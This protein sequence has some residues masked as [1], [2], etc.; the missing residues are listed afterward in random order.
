MGTKGNRPSRVKRPEPGTRAGTRSA[1]D[2]L[3]MEAERNWANSDRKAA[4]AARRTQARTNRRDPR[5]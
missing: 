5:S 3:R 1:S 4:K 2:A